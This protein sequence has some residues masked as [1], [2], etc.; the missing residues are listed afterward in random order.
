M[1]RA[2]TC[3][4]NGG[5][6]GPWPADGGN[7]NRQRDFFNTL[8]TMAAPWLPLGLAALALLAPSARAAV[9]GMSVAPH[10]CLAA[11]DAVQACEKAL[12][13]DRNN[14]PAR[15]SLCEAQLRL[16]DLDQ[17]EV[18]LRAGLESCEDGACQQ[19]TLAQS[20]VAE[21]RAAADRDDPRAAE[22]RIATQRRQC[23]SKLS[24][25]SNIAACQQ[26]LLTQHDLAFYEALVN[27]LLKNDDP[28][29]ALRY[30]LEARTKTENPSALQSLHE[31]ALQRREPQVKAC[32]KGSS[33]ALCDRVFVRSAPDAKAIQRK[34]SA[35]TRRVA[36][37]A[38]A[39]KAADSSGASAQPER[40]SPTLA[41]NTIQRDGTA[42]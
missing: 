30:T 33:L 9:C 6:P 42:H 2:A 32:L 13:D 22:R 25:P 20:N 3:S 26:L 37:G 35:L 24:R 38:S 7:T 29:S 12:A 41:R 27:K 19:L 4:E 17:A 39:A 40:S 21:R 8:R 23:L 28:I 5:A 14:L 15:L 10:P 11:G 36:D 16:N 18:S 31:R 34:R 1:V